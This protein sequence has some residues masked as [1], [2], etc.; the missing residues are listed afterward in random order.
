VKLVEQFLLMLLL[1]LSLCFG[2]CLKE[3]K[4]KHDIDHQLDFVLMNNREKSNKN[5]A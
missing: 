1:M 4:Y 3:A 2:G 5:R